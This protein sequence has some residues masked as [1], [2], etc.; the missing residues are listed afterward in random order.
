LEDDVGG[1]I[2]GGAALSP[3]SGAGAQNGGGGGGG[4]SS[5]GS[6]GTSMGT[7]RGILSAAEEK[8]AVSVV[9][10][11]A[12]AGNRI[13]LD[14]VRSTCSRLGTVPGDLRGQIWAHMLGMHGRETS[15]LSSWTGELDLSNQAE[16]HRDCQAAAKA[17]L[18]ARGL[19]SG[20]ATYAAELGKMSKEMELLLTVW[21][22]VLV[23]Y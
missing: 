18:E 1:G 6:L 4:R 13:D 7:E 10:E 9:R 17:V 21:C 23:W 8:E 19:S 20:G 22:M 15:S 12:A 16:L 2:Q 3:Q 5:A 11:Q 14:L